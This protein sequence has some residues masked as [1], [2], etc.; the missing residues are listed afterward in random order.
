MRKTSGTTILCM[1][2]T[3]VHDDL[4]GLEK[5]MPPDLRQRVGNN[6]HQL[7]IFKKQL[8]KKT[9]GSD[10]KFDEG[11][12]NLWVLWFESRITL[13]SDGSVEQLVPGWYQGKPTWSSP[14]TLH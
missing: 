14:V 3:T 11:P 6:A 2:L 7:P 10:W 1:A 4:C 9:S 5:V 13:R 12:V 8:W